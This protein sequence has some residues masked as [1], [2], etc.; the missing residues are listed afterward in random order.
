MTTWPSGP[1]R[2]ASW[3][4]GSTTSTP[5]LEWELPFAKWFVGGTLNISY[6]CL[7]RHV[8][9]GRGDKVAYYWEGE[10]GDTRIITYNDLYRDV[11]K[12]ANVLK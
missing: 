11:C 5:P 7:D 9:A 6:N 1:A 2:L 8:L 4:V 3:S 12:F 10:P